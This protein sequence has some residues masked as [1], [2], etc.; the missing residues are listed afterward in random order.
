MQEDKNKKIGYW[1]LSQIMTDEELKDFVKAVYDEVFAERIGGFDERYFETCLKRFRKDD[2]SE[3]DSD[4]IAGIIN[5]LHKKD[6]NH[7][8]ILSIWGNKI[9]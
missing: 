8:V 7:K 3:F 1:N 6:M 4:V 5:V 2:Y 9:N